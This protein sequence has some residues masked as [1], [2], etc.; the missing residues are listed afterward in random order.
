MKSMIVA[1]L[2]A[3]SVA[4]GVARDLALPALIPNP[5]KMETGEGVFKLSAK[6]RICADRPSRAT[7]E[8]L[9]ERLRVVTGYPI[10]SLRAN[11]TVMTS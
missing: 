3:G 9:A 8:Y 2:V 7:A 4:G 11:P 10:R 1:L 6:S 5:Q